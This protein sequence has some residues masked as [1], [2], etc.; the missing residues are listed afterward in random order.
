MVMGCLLAGAGDLA[1]REIHRCAIF[2][3]GIGPIR[4]GMT[5]S[6]AKNIFPEASFQRSSDGDGAALI[7]VSA[8]KEHLMTLHANEENA[9]KAIDWSR[10]IDVAETFNAACKTADGIFPGM[11]VREAEKK[12]GK[13]TRIVRSEIESREFIYF[14]KQPKDFVFRLDYS[15]IFPEGSRNTTKFAEGA[16]IFSIAVTRY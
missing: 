11:S 2:K 3:T 5:L 1:A 6:E 15:G 7:S 8:G 14:Q 13:T 12:L 9:D 16:R 10:K 4:L